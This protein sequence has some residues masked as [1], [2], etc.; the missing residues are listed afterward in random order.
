MENKNVSGTRQVGVTPKDFFL[1]VGWLIAL[2]AGVISLLNLLFETINRVFPDPLV[3]MQYPEGYSGPIQASIATLVVFFP[4]YILITRYIRKSF[5]TDPAR[6]EFWV[7]KWLVYLTLFLSI[8]A[9]VIDLILL[10]NRFLDG[11]LATQF[12]LKVLAL[13]I[14]V[15]AVFGYYFY[16][17][18][19]EGVINK[20]GNY[21]A[22]GTSILVVASLVWAF[23]VIGSPMTERLR[24]FD[25]QKVN[26]LEN[27]KN[28]VVFF[29]QAKGK[30][31]EN[32]A[33]LSDSISGYKAPVDPAT[34]APYEFKVLGPK[35]FE[36]CATFSL[37]GREGTYSP[38]ETIVRGNDSWKH[39]EGRTCFERVV[40]EELYPVKPKGTVVP[41][42]VY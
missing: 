1:N 9:A 33:A 42:P 22:I 29:W 37:P 28:N 27:I 36:L 31:P 25:D 3:R 13:L 19:N 40:D 8:L 24:R 26:D 39:G 41:K 7:R 5:E 6:R 12:L 18:R 11:N 16:D 32:L 20:V 15:G 10:I 23:T 14:V 34:E 38:Y 17:L 30:L 2:Y 35:S 4:I 21:F